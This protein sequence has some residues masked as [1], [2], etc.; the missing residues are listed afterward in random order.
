MEQSAVERM[1]SCHGPDF[2]SNF[3]GKYGGFSIVGP[4]KMVIFPLK[5]V[6]FHSYMGKSYI[7]WLV[8][9]GTM[10]SLMTFQKQLGN[11]LK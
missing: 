6:I 10:E 5:M 2:L 9:T 11:H 7:I 3:H 1:I 8:V 4:F